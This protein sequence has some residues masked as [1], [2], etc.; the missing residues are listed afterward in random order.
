M[1]LDREAVH[2]KTLF[3]KGRIKAMEEGQ[4]AEDG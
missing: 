2:R 1:I 3:P 4:V